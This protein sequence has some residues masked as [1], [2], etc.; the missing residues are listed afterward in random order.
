MR[1]KSRANSPKID[2]YTKNS[3]T[4]F[5]RCIGLMLLFP[6]LAGCTTAPDWDAN[7]HNIEPLRSSSG[8]TLNL[9]DP[10]ESLD[11]F[12]FQ[13]NGALVSGPLLPEYKIGPN[14]DLQVTLWGG[15]VLWSINTVHPSI[16]AHSTVVQTDGTITLP[17][18]GEI[19]VAGLSLAE[20]NV[21]LQ[22]RYKSALETPF[23]IEVA[24]NNP[25]SQA[26]T[27]EG[28]FNS[29]GIVHLGPFRKTLGQIISAAGGFA[30][31]ADTT[32]GILTRQG[33]QYAINYRASQQGQ[34]NLQNLILHEGDVLY[35]P[36]TSER[37]YYIFGEVIRQG[38]FPIPPQ[39][40]SI[41]EGIGRSWGPN[42]V[43]S[44]MERIFL[45]RS[46]SNSQKPSV[47]ELTLDEIMASEDIAL[48]PRDRI[49]IPPTGLTTWSRTLNQAL[50]GAGGATQI[51]EAVV[52]D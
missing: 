32:N 15:S 47:Y 39:G 14:D 23:Q 19:E 46:Y 45:I 33:T 29:S 25:R 21:A 10:T 4:C 12:D 2:K 26:V 43:T 51:T 11:H 13:G 38:A 22:S 20:A 35:F 1:Y 40:M 18:I 24:L 28:A 37:V 52:R 44:N 41:L 16:S 3:F 36:T 50:G 31:D 7:T 34:S 9:K 30:G 6:L 48:L 27:V 17:L 8:D 5:Y 49:F 42:M